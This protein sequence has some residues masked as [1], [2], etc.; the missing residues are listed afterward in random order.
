M[1]SAVLLG[2]LVAVAGCGG[3]DAPSPESVVHA[4]SAALDRNDNE[5]AA[6]LFADD[7]QVIQSGAFRLESHAD[8]V[9]WN[10]SLPCGGRITSLEPQGDSGDV[11]AVFVLTERPGH[12][13]DSP[14]ARAAALFSVRNGRITLWHQ[15]NPPP[16]SSSDGLTA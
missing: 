11:L 6:R 4:W 9:R 10:E 8:A 13:C 2:A 7:A 5:A 15:T 12:A 16:A 3:S 14:G 1:R